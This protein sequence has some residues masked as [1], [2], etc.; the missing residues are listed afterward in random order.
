MTRFYFDT[1]ALVKRYLPETGTSPFRALADPSSGHSI[2]SSE[3][4]QVEA[5]AALA[6][7]QRAPD[8]IALEVHDKAVDLLAEHC[9]AE[10][11]LVAVGPDILARAVSLT[12]NHRLRGYDAVQLARALATNETLLASELPALTFVAADE[13]LVAAAQVESL[14]SDDPNGHPWTEAPQP[15]G[16]RSGSLSHNETC[17]GC[18]VSRTTP[19]RSSPSLPTS[20]SSRNR[21]PNLTSVFWASYLRR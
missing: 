1:G 9:A 2:V 10:Y 16:L 14:T 18:S 11:R 8:G 13:D 17:S 3:I 19:T 21:T 7:R 12:Q 4:S 5:A 15:P 6:T 20:V